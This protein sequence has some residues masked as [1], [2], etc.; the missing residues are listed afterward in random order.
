MIGVYITIGIVGLILSS[1]LLPVIASILYGSEFDKAS[2]DRITY[3]HSGVRLWRSR[4]ETSSK[5]AFVVFT[6]IQWLSGILIGGCLISLLTGCSG[7]SSLNGPDF[8]GT[9]NIGELPA[10]VRLVAPV[11]KVPMEPTEYCDLSYPENFW[12]ELTDKYP[13]RPPLD[14]PSFCF[15]CHNEETFWN[16]HAR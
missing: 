2:C 1:I 8:T 13:P 5:V 4:L 14:A 9:E 3:A 6:V 11:G 10:P 12:Y 16:S 15:E 7:S